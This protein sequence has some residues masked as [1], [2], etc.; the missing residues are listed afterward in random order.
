MNA[1]Q[2]ISNK[3]YDWTQDNSPFVSR[4]ILTR[5]AAVAL[6]TVEIVELA[7][8]PFILTHRVSTALAGLPLKGI[9]KFMPSKRARELDETFATPLQA[10][11]T[12]CKIIQMICG[13]A[14][15]AL[16]GI[17]VS[18]SLNYSI[19]AHPKI[20]LV[21]DE[22]VRCRHTKRTEMERQADAFLIKHRA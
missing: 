8:Q 7:L 4:H 19:H 9:L 5:L 22:L 6:C 1:I 15:T 16:F 14:S 10:W 18:P 2:S 17:I 11:H 13:F 21:N 20:A 3:I 12:A